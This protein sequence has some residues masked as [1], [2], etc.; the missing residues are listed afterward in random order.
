[1]KKT[2]II[3]THT[4]TTTYTRRVLVELTYDLSCKD[5]QFLYTGPRGNFPLETVV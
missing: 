4:N 3:Q 1:M 5:R 2:F